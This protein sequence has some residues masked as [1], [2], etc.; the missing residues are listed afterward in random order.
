MRKNWIELNDGKFLLKDFGKYRTDLLI[1]SDKPE[2]NY[3]KI[4]PQE[5]NLDKGDL[6]F[7]KGT[8]F[9]TKKGANAFKIEEEG[10]HLLIRDDWGGAF[11]T[12]RGWSLFELEN[13]LFKRRASSNGCGMGYDYVVVPVGSKYGV[14]IEDL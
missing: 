7:V 9:V 12:Y 13:I 5:F 4:S 3:E 1:I 11:N 10:K 6:T 8:F 2:I 14:S